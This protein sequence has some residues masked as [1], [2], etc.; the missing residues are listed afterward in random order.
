MVLRRA[1]AILGDEQ[2]AGDALQEVFI[3]ALQS[4]SEFRAQ[5]S[6][7]TWLYRITTN[8]CLNLIRDRSRRSQLLSENAPPAEGA[9]RGTLDD[10]LTMAKL[11]ERTPAELRE[12]AIYYFV[13]QMNQDEIAEQLGLSRRTVGNRLEAFKA[14]ARAASGPVEEVAS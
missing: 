4:G 5:A 13:D 11:L 3:R 8:Y 1:R 12:I 6:P 14:A 2:A 10:Q 9:A 7:V